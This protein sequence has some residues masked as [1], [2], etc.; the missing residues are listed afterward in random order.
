MTNLTPDLSGRL[1]PEQRPQRRRRAPVAAH[2]RSEI[3]DRR[4]RPRASRTTR[5]QIRDLTDDEDRIR[6]NINSLKVVSG[7]QQQVQNYA[8]QLD[9]HEQQLVALRD[10]GAELNKKHTTLQMELNKLV[11]ALTF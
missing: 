5:N 8:R 4:K 10:A 9:E 2:R 7:Q 3:A 1:H 11:D 6:Q